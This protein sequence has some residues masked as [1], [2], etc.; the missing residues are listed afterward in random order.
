MT[1]CEVTEFG[2]CYYSPLNRDEMIF[3]QTSSILL[4]YLPF[5]PLSPSV[6]F[7]FLSLNKCFEPVH[8]VPDIVL[9]TVNLEIQRLVPHFCFRHAQSH[10][11]HRYAN[12]DYPVRN[13]MCVQGIMQ[14]RGEKALREARGGVRF[15]PWESVIR[16]SVQVH[17]Y[18]LNLLSKPLLSQTLHQILGIWTEKYTVE[19]SRSF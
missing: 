4:F 10:W 8:N 15:R 13:V 18:T 1:Y 9:G 2:T 7:Y 6:L 3:P 5:F 16:H 19:A 11:R 14:P 17:N 12:N